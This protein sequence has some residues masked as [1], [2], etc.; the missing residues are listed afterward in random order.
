[1]SQHKAAVLEFRCSLELRTRQ[2][3]WR[4]TIKDPRTSSFGVVRTMYILQDDEYFRH[5][6]SGWQTKAIHINDKPLMHQ[7]CNQIFY[8]LGYANACCRYYMHAQAQCTTV[9]RS[10]YTAL[11]KHCKTWK[12]PKINRSGIVGEHHRAAPYKVI[13]S[14]AWFGARIVTIHECGGS[15]LPVYITFVVRCLLQ[16]ALSVEV[17][18]S[19]VTG[20]CRSRSS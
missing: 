11:T 4:P 20:A 1:M 14:P 18:A 6:L 8:R 10:V 2:L 13:P 9:W 19:N 12:P 7:Y 17:V 5:K 3:E 16:V 15:T